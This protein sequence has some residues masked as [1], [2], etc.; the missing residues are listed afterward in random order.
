MSNDQLSAYERIALQGVEESLR[1][2]DRE[3]VERFD[4]DAL[5]LD[6]EAARWR[7]TVFQWLRRAG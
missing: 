2:D 4:L 6:R 1:H 5:G 3:F 7:D